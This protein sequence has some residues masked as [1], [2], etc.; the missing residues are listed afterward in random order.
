MTAPVVDRSSN[1]NEQ[2]VHAAEVIGGSKYRRRVFKEI[3]TGKTKVKTVTLLIQKTKFPRTRTLDAG[4]A[5]AT[6]EIVRQTKVDG[7]TAYEKIDFFQRYR[8]KVLAAADDLAK[9]AAIPTKRSRASSRSPVTVTV[10]IPKAGSRATHVTIDDIDSFKKV[11]KVPHG[12]DPVRM[13]ETTFKNGVAAILGERATFKDWGGELRDLS[14]THLKIAGKR[15]AAA[16][17]FKGPGTTGKLTPAKFGKNGDQI[18]RLSRCPAEAFFIQYWSDIDDASFEQLEKLV[19]LKSYLE[20]R[21]LWY[22]MIDGDDS[23]RLIQA[24]ATAFSRRR[25]RASSPKG[26]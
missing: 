22:G 5:L 15:R 19:Q 7:V 18:Q 13:A 16:F 26:R 24:Y 17:A 3:Y 2:I 20:G 14:S 8:D 4:L 11:R 6:N 1:K 23:A 10:R 21:K 12:L 25:S 9:R